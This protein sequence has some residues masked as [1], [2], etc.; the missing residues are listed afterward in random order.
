M[1]LGVNGCTWDIPAT[2]VKGL[3]TGDDEQASINSGRDESRVRLMIRAREFVTE[4]QQALRNQS[5]G[6]RMSSVV[7]ACNAIGRR[8]LTVASEWCGSG[9]RQEGLAMQFA[10]L[11][12]KF[13][14]LQVSV[15]QW[16][17]R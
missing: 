3:I 4:A 10:Q 7:K 11:R 14:L 8:R 13:G 5:E 17:S 15:V 9:V 2:V 16:K 12:E 6:M 1:L